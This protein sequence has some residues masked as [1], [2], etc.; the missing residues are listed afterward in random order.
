MTTHATAWKIRRA[1][2]TVEGYTDHDRDR[3]VDS[4]LYKTAAGYAPSAVA[5]RSDLSADNQQV[6]GIIDSVDITAQNL[7][8]GIYDG[9]RVDMLQIDW[10]VQTL[11]RTLLVGFMGRPKVAGERY[12][13]ELHSIESELQKPIGR[14]VELRCQYDLGDSDCGFTL[15]ADSSVVDS[16]TSARRVFVDAALAQADGYYNHGKV[17][18]TTGSNAGLVSDV[19]RYL[20]GTDTVELFEPLPFDIEVGDGYDIFRG[21]DKTFA[22]CKGTFSRNKTT[23]SYPHVPGEANLVAGNTDTS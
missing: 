17:E 18:W 2:T 8:N 14:L 22:T 15:T 3:T 21:C 9:A 6:V 1:D 5:R 10:D 7:L 12:E 23:G 19:K 13:I 16:V 4:Q 20:S 11:V